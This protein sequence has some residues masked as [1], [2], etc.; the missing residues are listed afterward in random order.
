MLINKLDDCVQDLRDLFIEYDDLPE[1]EQ[2]N[3]RNEAYRTF[4]DYA[5][6]LF[7]DIDGKVVDQYLD[8]LRI[9]GERPCKWVVETDQGVKAFHYYAHDADRAVRVGEK[10]GYSTTEKRKFDPNEDLTDLGLWIGRF[11][12]L[13]YDRYPL[14]TGDKITVDGWNHC[15]TEPCTVMDIKTRTSLRAIVR[16]A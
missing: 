7:K 5:T 15:V 14:R 1:T 11:G 13:L 8:V 9:T 12:K 16:E 2:S 6:A 10:L 4:G 3:F